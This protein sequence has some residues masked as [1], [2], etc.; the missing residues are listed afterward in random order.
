[1]L[2]VD[3]D[4]LALASTTGL[5]ESWGCKSRATDSQAGILKALHRAATPPDIILSDYQIAGRRRAGEIIQQ[6]RAAFRRANPGRH[7]QRRHLV[8]QPPAQ[9][10]RPTFPCSTS[11]FGLPGC[12]PCC[13]AKPKAD[14]G[15]ASFS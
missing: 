15:R 8:G 2:L 1:V 9:S 6:L 5:L 7:P 11:P 13:S 3:D 14:A 10:S 12:A 4:E